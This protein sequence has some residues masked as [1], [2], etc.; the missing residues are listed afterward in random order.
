MIFEFSKQNNKSLLLP[1]LLRRTK[2][3][4]IVYALL[5]LLFKT[6]IVI[7]ESNDVL[8]GTQINAGFELID[9]IINYD[10]L[11]IVKNQSFTNFA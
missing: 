8:F 5:I 7:T 9:R 3:M 10:S 6:I 11:S 2:G 4:E 1:S